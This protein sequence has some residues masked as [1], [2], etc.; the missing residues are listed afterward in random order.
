MT[1]TTKQHYKYIKVEESEY[2]YAYEFKEGENARNIKTFIIIKD[3][4]FV[5]INNTRPIIIIVVT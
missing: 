2:E 5:I 1:I 3:T 4:S